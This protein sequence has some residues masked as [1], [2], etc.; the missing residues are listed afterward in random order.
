MT[1]SAL[2]RV[3]PWLRG[4]ALTLLLVALIAPMP[5][6]LLDVLLVANLAASLVVLLSSAA[7]RPPRIVAALPAVLLLGALARLALELAASRAILA[8]A[9][10]GA[11]ITAFGSVAVRGDALVGAAVFVILTVVQLV[12]V[13]QGGERVA[14]VAARFALDAMPGQQ[15]AIDAAARGGS[16]DAR[17]ARREREALERRAQRAGAMD[18]AMRFVKGDAIA[19]VVIVLVNLIVGTLLGV[20]RDGLAAAGAAQRYATLA[21]GQGLLAQVPSMLLAVAAALSVSRAHGR[22]DDQHLVAPTT[23]RVIAGVL[24]LVGVAPG[25]PLWPFA[26]VAAVLAALS[27][28]PRPSS[29]PPKGQPDARE[30]VDIDDT[31]RRLDALSVDAPALVRATSPTLISA[32]Q[33]TALRRWLAEEDLPV[34]DLRAVLEAVLRAGALDDA[35]ERWR[36]KVRVS[37]G[38]LVAARFAPDGAIAVWMVGPSV[39]AAMRDELARR[40]TLGAAL[41]DD[42]RTMVETGCSGEEA[43]VLLAAQPVRRALWESLRGGRQRCAVLAPEELGDAVQI[44]VRGVLDPMG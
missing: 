31:E 3:D 35:E 25:F 7:A 27:L 23:L 5:T 26:L 44:T 38:P 14:E 32:A 6:A 22:P 12:V 18:G 40:P 37:L 15:L 20:A 2:A 17:H 16:I 43:V 4:G 28:F 39:E 10:P 30:L 29:V 33:L 13:V 36:S 19:G 24:L 21:I 8:G 42:L 1:S 11:V 9:S 34:G 41:A